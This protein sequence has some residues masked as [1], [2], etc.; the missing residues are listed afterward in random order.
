[1]KLNPFVTS[2][3][4]KNRKRHFNA[5][6]HI[7]RKIMS[8]P[9]SKE[10]RQKYNVRSMPI[11]KDDEV[12]V[13][14]WGSFQPQRAGC[15]CLTFLT[16]LCC[17]QT[18]RP[19]TLQRPAD[20]QSGPGLQEE[21]R[22]LHRACAE[23]KGQRNHSPCRHPPQ[24]GETKLCMCGRNKWKWGY[25]TAWVTAGRTVNANLQSSALCTCHDSHWDVLVLF[26]PVWGDVKI[27]IVRLSEVQFELWNILF[28]WRAAPV[29]FYTALIC[30]SFGIDVG[31]ITWRVLFSIR[32]KMINVFEDSLPCDVYVI[33]YCLVFGNRF[34]FNPSLTMGCS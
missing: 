5:P 15:T 2:S 25:S 14:Y 24:Q 28:L 20:W 22:H 1:M 27:E 26:C 18:G 32:F 21:V 3:R 29:F 13:M 6:S 9:L 12:Q 34:S 31:A 7:R 33:Q 10:L 19:W 11:R 16:R 4:R 17:L 23:R 8:S 30:R